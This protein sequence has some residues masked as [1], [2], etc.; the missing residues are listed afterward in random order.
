MSGRRE[1]VRHEHE[2]RA[3]KGPEDDFDRLASVR[4]EQ[5]QLIRSPHPAES[6]IYQ[7]TPNMF[8]YPSNKISFEDLFRESFEQPT[9]MH[10]VTILF[11][12]GQNPPRIPQ[13]LESKP[14]H[15][16]VPQ[17]QGDKSNPRDKIVKP[18]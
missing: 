17:P 11:K 12:T 7:P 1:S 6:G 2:F 4:D 16:D 3:D 5:I 8:E 14:S 13:D 10:A 18:T 9:Q 15:H